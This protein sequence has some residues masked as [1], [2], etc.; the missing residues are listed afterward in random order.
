MTWRM[1]GP[2]AV[3]LAALLWVACDGDPTGSGLAGSAATSTI[4]ATGVAVASGASLDIGLVV[5]DADGQPVGRGGDVVVFELSGG[6]STG[7]LSGTVDR[8][9]GTYAATIVGEMAGTPMSVIARLNGDSVTTAPP[10]VAVVA[11]NGSPATS[12]VIVSSATLDVG[13]SSEIRMEA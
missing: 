6:T 3:F 10:T 4:T 9:D 7:R 5:N 8:G 2:R 13:S 12:L 1:G 11:G